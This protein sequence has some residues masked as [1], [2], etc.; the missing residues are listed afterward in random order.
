[1]VT[2]SVF[3]VYF[4]IKDPALI[5]RRKQVASPEQ[6]TLQKIIAAIAFTGFAALFVFSALDH[7]FAWSQVPPPVSWI[8]N[9]LVVLSFFIYYLVFKENSYGGSS[10]LTFLPLEIIKI[11]NIIVFG[12]YK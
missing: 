9:V 2:M 6:S 5:E 3:G 1:M 4:S 7:R 12:Y 11:D 8:G 10:I